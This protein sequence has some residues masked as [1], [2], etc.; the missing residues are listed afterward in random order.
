MLDFVKKSIHLNTLKLYQNFFTFFTF[1]SF[2]DGMIV[3]SFLTI[4][5]R[6]RSKCV[7]SCNT[8]ICIP[9]PNV[10]FS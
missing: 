4:L 2:S 6:I 7:G 1:F 5:S 9:L 8:E 3:F 10:V